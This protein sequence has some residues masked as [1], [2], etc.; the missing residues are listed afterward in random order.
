MSDQRHCGTNREYLRS[1]LRAEFPDLADRVVSKE[2]SVNRAAILAGISP[3]RISLAGHDPDTI[4]AAL[5]RYL[6]PE[7]RLA[8]A[9]R[10]AR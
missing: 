4:A 8:V 6:P 5:R 3:P 1:R 10:L 9:E 7:V 2:L